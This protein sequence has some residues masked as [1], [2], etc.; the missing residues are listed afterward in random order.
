VCGLLTDLVSHPHHITARPE[1][2]LDDS[3]HHLDGKV[4]DSE[5]YCILHEYRHTDEQ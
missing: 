5:G 4:A 2:D 1:T 3:L